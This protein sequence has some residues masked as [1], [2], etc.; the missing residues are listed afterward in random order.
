MNPK[1]L[2]NIYTKGLVDYVPVKPLK[3]GYVKRVLDWCIQ[4][5]IVMWWHD[6]ILRVGVVMRVVVAGDD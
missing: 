1:L 5:F 3:H 4:H 6:T 2:A